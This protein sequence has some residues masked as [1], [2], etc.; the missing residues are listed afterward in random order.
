MKIVKTVLNVLALVWLI[1]L[2]FVGDVYLSWL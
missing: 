2:A 1:S